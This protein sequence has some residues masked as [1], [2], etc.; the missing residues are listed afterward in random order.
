MKN[1][2]ELWDLVLCQMPRG[3][4]IAGGA[5]RDYFL[6]V[7]PKDIDVF[8]P[9]LVHV[10]AEP[11]A[12]YS[13]LSNLIASDPRS[14]LYRIEDRYEREE[15]YKALGDIA[16]VSRGKIGNISVDLIEMVSTE[17]DP[18]ALIGGFDFGITR[19]FYDGK[20]V[21]DTPEALTD[22]TN[23]SVTLLLGDRRE[24]ALKRFERFNV[25]MGGE[26]T[27]IEAYG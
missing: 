4:V 19:C 2:P 11:D 7:E 13:D 5:V 26:F 16:T 23:K 8:A 18:W 14:G 15:E 6:G 1:G 25:R 12:S 24:R 21:W 9:A 20:L 22:R 10:N 27:L 3:A 17:L